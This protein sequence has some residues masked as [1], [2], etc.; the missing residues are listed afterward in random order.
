MIEIK[1]VQKKKRIREE[2]SLKQKTY[3]GIGLFVLLTILTFQVFIPMVSRQQGRAM[4]DAI[5]E[6]ITEDHFELMEAERQGIQFFSS[7]QST[8][9]KDLYISTDIAPPDLTPARIHFL[10]ERALTE[11][12]GTIRRFTMATDDSL[13]DDLKILLGEEL[14]RVIGSFDQSAPALVEFD[15]PFVL[16]KLPGYFPVADIRA[17]ASDERFLQDAS[18]IVGVLTSRPYQSD[19]L[20]IAYTTDWK[21]AVVYRW[22]GSVEDRGVTDEIRAALA[23]LRSG[24]TVNELIISEEVYYNYPYNHDFTLP[25]Q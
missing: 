16:G 20:A 15:E 11:K 7:F 12:P 1:P 4:A 10:Y 18:V 23:R 13:Y 3:I 5:N 8:R 19:G 2:L 6:V 22:Y 21:T 24:E 9:Y 17:A 25:A 14:L